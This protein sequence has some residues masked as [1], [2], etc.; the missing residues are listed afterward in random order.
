MNFFWMIIVNSWV[1]ILDDQRGIVTNITNQK[2]LSY[3]HF[4]VGWWQSGATALPECWFWPWWCPVSKPSWRS[5]NENLQPSSCLGSLLSWSL[6]HMM[7]LWS[8]LLIPANIHFGWKSWWYDRVHISSPPPRT[9][10]FP[11]KQDNLFAAG[12]GNSPK[13][14][15]TTSRE[16][17]GQQ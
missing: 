10:G 9:A 14:E 13:T 16:T 1:V 11:R 8:I 12:A 3:I 5:Q 15:V 4:S 6:L 7:M 2:F 17:T